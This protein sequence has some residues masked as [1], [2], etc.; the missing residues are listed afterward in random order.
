MT[1]ISRRIGIGQAMKMAGHD[2]MRMSLLY[3]LAEREEQEAAIRADQ[4]QLLIG[5]AREEAR[6]Q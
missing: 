4:E 3:T 2:S 1:K 6:V 5:N